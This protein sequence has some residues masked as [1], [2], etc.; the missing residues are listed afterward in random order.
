M[1]QR[2]EQPVVEVSAREVGDA[3][4]QDQQRDGDREHAV[5]EREDSV[6]AA[7][8]LADLGACHVVMVVWDGR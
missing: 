6:E 5:A 4:V 1:G 7:T 2:V 8:P 3:E